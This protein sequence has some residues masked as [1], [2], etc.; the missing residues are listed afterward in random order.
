MS[1]D[2]IATGLIRV[3][4]RLVADNPQYQLGEG[5]LVDQLVGQVMAHILDLGYLANKENIKKTNEAI[6]KYN[7]RENLVKH[8]N[9]M[10][11]YAYGDESALLMAAYPGARPK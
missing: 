1:I 9:F 2:N 5:V 7:Y 8:P 3:K 11:S 10:R 6:L 4:R